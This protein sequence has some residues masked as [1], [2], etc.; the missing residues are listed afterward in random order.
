MGTSPITSWQR[1]REKVAAVTDFFYLGSK[2]TADD[3][4]SLEIRR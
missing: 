1:E 3:D 4:C 2:N